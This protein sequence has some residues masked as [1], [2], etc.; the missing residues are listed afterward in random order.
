MGPTNRRAFLRDSLATSA[1]LVFP[2]LVRADKG[3]AVLV[4]AVVASALRRMQDE[5]KPGLVIVVPA[6]AEKAQVRINALSDWLGGVEMP[7]PRGSEEKIP[8][9]L[10]AD[11]G[12]AV[13]QLLCQAVL[14]CVP[15]PE[16]QKRWGLQETTEYAVLNADGKVLSESAATEKPSRLTPAL[17]ELVHGP[18][19]E[20]RAAYARRQK[21]ALGEESTARITS[22]L[23]NLDSP[24]FTTRQ[25]A[26]EQLAPLAAKV[27]AVLA[28]V[29]AN[30]PNLDF[31]H[32]VEGLFD[33]VYRTAPKNEPG[34]RQPFG[35]RWDKE[36]C[37]VDC[38]LACPSPS[39]RLFL[40]VFTEVKP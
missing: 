33:E 7:L 18:R 30:K 24:D 35:T 31:R 21:A 19:G 20:H 12:A 40:R 28:E 6:E 36:I 17:L 16:A 38:G 29:L 5:N 10:E 9:G 4:G 2:F 22:A 1:V 27:P 25:E 8:E 3:P 15:R 23:R 26:N 34:I 37:S 32:R 11:A 39:A 13:R 14:V